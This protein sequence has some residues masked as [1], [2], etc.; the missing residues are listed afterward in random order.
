[1]KFA[2]N[3]C[4]FGERAMQQSE[5]DIAVESFAGLR[6]TRIFCK[7]FRV[8]LILG[9]SSLLSAWT[10]TAVVNL[11]PCPGATPYPQIGALSPNPISADAVSVEL[12]VEGNGFIPQSGI[13]WNQN[14]LPTT[15]IDS[16][17]LETTVTQST[18]ESYGGSAGTD[19]SIT[20]TSPAST[21]GEAGCPDAGNSSTLLLKI[22]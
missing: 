5:Q 22:N 6:C 21:Y 12:I 1:M 4:E 15:F 19:V 2:G 16:R 13:L 7:P 10:C 20:V 11:R 18:F 9:L 14:P 3:N 17:H 8:I